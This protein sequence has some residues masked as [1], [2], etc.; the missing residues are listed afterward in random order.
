MTRKD[1]IRIARAI[2]HT[3]HTTDARPDADARADEIGR[4]ADAIARELAAD[5]GRFDYGRFM[6]AAL[7]ALKETPEAPAAPAPVISDPIAPAS[8]CDELWGVAA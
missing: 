5:N 6:A 4:V 2:A 8:L 7:P 1:Y 3:Y